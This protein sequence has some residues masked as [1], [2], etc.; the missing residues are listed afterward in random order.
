MRNEAVTAEQ[1][2]KDKVRA[3]AADACEKKDRTCIDG[4]SKARGTLLAVKLSPLPVYYDGLM[5]YS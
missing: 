3:R 4:K 2:I 1:I 5:F